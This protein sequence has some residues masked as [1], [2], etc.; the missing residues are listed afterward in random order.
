MEVPLQALAE[1]RVGYP[2]RT[3]VVPD[4]RG[5]TAIVQLSDLSEGTLQT[6][7]LTRVHL[8]DV[9]PH[10]HLR[11]RDILFRSRSMV[12][13]ATLLDVPPALPPGVTRIVAV[14]PIIIIRPRLVMDAAIRKKFAIPP[15]APGAKASYLHWLLNHPRTQSLLRSRST[16][17]NAE[18]LRKGDLTDLPIPL[19][20]RE[21]QEL[22]METAAL[23]QQELRY[24]RQLI[25]DRRKMVE[26]TLLH[27]AWH[28]DTAYYERASDAPD[29]PS[30]FEQDDDER[31]FAACDMSPEPP[32]RPDTRTAAAELAAL[33]NELD[34]DAANRA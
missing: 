11:Q 23:L 26:D 3:R 16:G 30:Q 14:A 20:P 29:M 10:F 28:I 19:P 18:V 32:F 8:T 4:P 31:S 27:H 12:N 33:M 7:K 13:D 1:I 34:D 17:D 22:I 5:E 6:A 21:A 9:K 2:F 15:T 25:E 24:R